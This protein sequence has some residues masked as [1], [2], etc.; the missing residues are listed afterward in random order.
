MEQKVAA[1]KAELEAI[2]AKTSAAKERAANIDGAQR[3][4]V[5]CIAAMVSR[6]GQ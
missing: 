3:D 5:K 2:R 1:S 4:I 6:Q